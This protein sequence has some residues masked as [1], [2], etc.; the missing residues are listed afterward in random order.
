MI[1][2]KLYNL[3]KIIL[4]AQLFFCGNLQYVFAATDM[5]TS[6]YQVLH[7]FQGGADGANPIADLIQ[8]NDGYL[9]GTTTTGGSSNN[10][11]VF[12]ISPNGVENVIY[13][14]RGGADDGANPINAG[15]VQGSD[16]YLYG[17]TF[18][19]GINNNGTV[20]KI[21]TSGVE[22]VI[23][24]FQSGADGANPEA[25]LTW[26]NDGYFYG[27]TTHGGGNNSGTV[28]RISPAGNERVIYYLQS[29][30]DGIIPAGLTLGRDGYFY[31]T[32][33]EG[34]RC[35]WPGGFCG[36]V[37]KIS[38]A[39]NGMV[40]HSF[41]QGGGTQDGAIP[42]DRLLQNRDGYF[43]GTTALGGTSFLGLGG[44]VFKISE[45]GDETVI[46]S[47]QDANGAEPAAGLIQ[48]RNGYLY[49]TTTIGG[50]NANGT[51]FKITTSGDET[52]VHF[53]Q[54]SD[55]ASPEASLIQARDGY[56]YGTTATGGYN[57]YGVVFKILD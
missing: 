29:N 47:F 49:G 55:G 10:G 15:L 54:G 26:G 9:Y 28:F 33:E 38:P 44:T 46:Y 20:Y 52:V 27:T 41:D 17:T 56:F 57:N 45:S 48:A 53:F 16:G 50:N 32:T 13:S 24:Y 23:H 2:S 36:T 30:Y 18:G 40:I 11:T 37:F 5:H 51:V 43:Y 21:S 3:L 14:F 19:G 25:G 8:A 4:L 12:K 42:S 35:N 22:N 6:S 1:K 31:G 7:Y 39:G 34:P